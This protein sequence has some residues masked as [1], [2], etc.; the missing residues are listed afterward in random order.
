[1]YTYIF[2]FHARSYNFLHQLVPLAEV[3]ADRFDSYPYL[4]LSLSSPLIAIVALLLFFF[5]LPPPPP[6]V[7]II[8]SK[9]P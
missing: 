5:F 1:M 9:T 8:S 7:I 3:E 2:Y 4:L 6:P